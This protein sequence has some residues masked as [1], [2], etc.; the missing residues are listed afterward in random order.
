[1]FTSSEDTEALNLGAARKSPCL[2]YPFCKG[3]VSPE[4]GQILL[5]QF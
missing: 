4:D 1:M 2:K 3:L 5:F